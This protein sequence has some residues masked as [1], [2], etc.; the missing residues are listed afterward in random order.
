LSQPFGIAEFSHNL[1]SDQIRAAIGP[2]LR[3]QSRPISLYSMTIARRIKHAFRGQV[4]AKAA[5]FEIGRRGCVAL[6]GRYERIAQSYDKAG[7]GP[8]RLVGEFAKIPPSE[9][10]EHFRT[11]STPRFFAGFNTALENQS[12]LQRREFP[13][14]TAALLDGAR[15]IVNNHRWPLLG[16]GELGFGREIEWL[17]EPVSGANWPR[18]FYADVALTPAGNADVRVLWE[19]NR[20]AHLLTLGQAY[21]VTG[22]E[23]FADE[24]FVQV[25]SW[26]AQNRIGF[27]P[28]W[29]CAMEVA[30]RAMNL[31]TALRLFRDSSKLTEERLQ[32]M[33]TL[34]EEHGEY[35]RHHLEFSYIATSNHYLSDVVGLLWLGVCLPELEQ[36]AEW[37][38]YGLRE[39]LREMDKQIL[40]DGAHYEASTGYHRFVLEL[41][42]YSFILCRANSIEIAGRY[43]EKL[44][45]M[46]EYLRS[47]L[48]PDGKAP[49]IGDTDSGQV[50]P[51][52]SH[53]A[54]D[55]SYLLG[56]A[57]VLLN[58]PNFKITEKPPQEIVWLLGE[59]ALERFR[60]LE[61]TGPVAAKSAGF[62]EAGTFVLRDRDSYLLFNA[63]GT[64][65]AGRGAHGHNDALS[66]EVAACGTS[67]I[68]DPGTYVYSSDL[69]LRHQFR[70]T[71]FHS[72]V[73]VDG[74][75]Q[76][77]TEEGTQIRLG[78]QARPRV[79]RWESAD[80]RDLVIA[81]HHGYKSLPNGPVTHTRAVLFEK[82]ERF[83][84]IDD[85]L[86]GSGRHTF[87]F[88]FHVAPG[89]EVLP[90]EEGL[91]EIRNKENGAR[92][93]IASIDLNAQP[94]LEPRWF[95]RDY[96]AKIP[97]VALCWKLEA[98]APL[99]VRWLLVPICAGEDTG[100][101]L[102]L[103][104]HLKTAPI[105]NLRSEIS[106]LRS[107]DKR[108][109]IN[110]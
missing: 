84:Q 14:A 60:G 1:G 45:F 105:G 61:T 92:L 95:S 53:T 66:L 30:L 7:R 58:E 54:T 87:R 103:V 11:R 51:M 36:A 93:L 56:I 13:A 77:T 109:K 90:K 16:Y 69:A 41:F 10:L 25:E 100:T 15:N 81:E 75:E 28:N 37:R 35:I 70:S 33:L 94:V 57:A 50:M 21:A 23:G 55:H 24:F 80:Q 64:G 38:T 67:F 86:I 78:N 68:S 19:L 91:T 107:Q 104:E 22:D 110:D 63:G 43:W 98:E 26:R 17:R 76:N 79:L 44:R 83:W 12:D 31:L 8:A 97:S 72:T 96:G 59:E 73:E 40:T 27:G 32:T 6:R 71:G 18:D 39:M 42:L 74:R 99:H 2:E 4:G 47:Y 48:R 49:L 82:S 34:F 9:L 29:S 52:A 106:D 5:V 85:A 102:A 65:L 3:P 108:L 20:L 88:C 89:L 46:L 101:R 62:S